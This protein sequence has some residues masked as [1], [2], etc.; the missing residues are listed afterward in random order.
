[1]VKN[2]NN[3]LVSNKIN[4]V[5]DKIVA[6]SKIIDEL[7]TGFTSPCPDEILKIREGC[8]LVDNSLGRTTETGHF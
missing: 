8:E 2:M 7:P 4:I 3:V 5:M 6:Q 1:M